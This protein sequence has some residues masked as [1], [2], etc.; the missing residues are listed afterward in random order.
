MSQCDDSDTGRP[1]C[2][3][4]CCWYGLYLAPFLPS[5]L[6]CH[7]LPFYA[8]LHPFTTQSVCVTCPLLSQLVPM[9]PLLYI[10]NVKCLLLE[11]IHVHFFLFTFFMLK[12]TFPHSLILSYFFSSLLQIPTNTFT[13]KFL[14]FPDTKD[15][16]R[17][18]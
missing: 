5:I 12:S 11:F 2:C 6:P 8:I 15:T 13:D 7:S 17:T 10:V 16:R 18:I 14:F 4:T 1:D 9:C 3:C